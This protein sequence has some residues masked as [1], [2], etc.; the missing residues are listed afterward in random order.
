MLPP[1]SLSKNKPWK[2]AEVGSLHFRQLLLA[3]CLAEPSFLPTEFS[4]YHRYQ[5]FEI[6]ASHCAMKSSVF[7][8]VSYIL[9]SGSG[10]SNFSEEIVA[11]IFKAQET[12]NNKKTVFYVRCTVIL[13]NTVRFSDT[14][15]NFY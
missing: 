12:E 13:K 4:L 14:S 10:F 3:S 1:S 6:P 15:V 11:S 7:W 9:H 8:D 2:T 5:R